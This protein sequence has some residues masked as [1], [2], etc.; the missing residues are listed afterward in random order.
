VLLD[1]VILGLAIALEPFPLVAFILILGARHGTRKGLGFILGWLACLVAVLAAV[2]VLRGPQP[3]KPDTLPSTAVLV[4]KIILG[5][6]LLA[7]ALR[8]WRHKGAPRKQPAWTGRLDRLSPWAAAGLGAFLQP[9]TLVAAGAATVVRAD[10]SHAGDYL[11]LL[12]FCLLATS[13]FLVMEVWATLAPQAAAV[14]LGGVR[15]WID[16]HRDQ[17]IVLV[18]LVVGLWLAATGLRGLMTG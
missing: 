17:A 4:V 11:A 13:S 6:L 12:F 10:L 9:W 1:L 15:L 14:R 7:V 5:V 2:V 8:A 3:P 16:G 18:S